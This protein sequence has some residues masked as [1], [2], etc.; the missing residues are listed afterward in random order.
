MRVYDRLLAL[1]ASRIVVLATVL[2][3]VVPAARSELH[4]FDYTWDSPAGSLTVYWTFDDVTNQWCRTGSVQPPGLNGMLYAIYPSTFTNVWSGCTDMTSY[5]VAGTLD[6]AKFR[7]F[8]TYNNGASNDWS[9][10]INIFPGE[11]DTC[12]PVDFQGSV[13]NSGPGDKNY[14][15]IIASDPEETIASFTLEQGQTQQYN[16]QYE[17]L[18]DAIGLWELNE[19]GFPFKLLDTILPDTPNPPDSP[20][21][22]PEEPVDTPVDTP[23]PEYT[24]IEDSI[25]QPLIDDPT[26]SDIEK[27]IESDHILWQRTDQSLKDIEEAIEGDD[28]QGQIDYTSLLE[29]IRDNVKEHNE[30]DDEWTQRHLDAL[31]ANPTESEMA[32]EGQSAANAAAALVPQLS[33][34]G[35]F[36]PGSA[37]EWNISIMEHTFN[38]NPF[39]FPEIVDLANWIRLGFAFFF[40]IGFAT[41]A[42][43]TG[44]EYIQAL[45]QVNQAKGNAAVGGTGGQAT[46]LI[47]AGLITVAVATTLVALFSWA[48][49]D[50][51][52]GDISS[53]MGYHPFNGS[54]VVANAMWMLDQFIPLGGYIGAVIGKIIWRGVA[55]TAFVIAMSI[56]RF[57]VP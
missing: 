54:G 24:P 37:P 57:V 36:S 31:D 23:N 29:E 41:W 17:E 22:P 7:I 45:A 12:G 9:E 21:E 56:I 35:S 52:I 42:S 5:V 20:I 11:P 10:P 6:E 51:G 8:I 26:K 18:C 47:A 34:S 46:A 25:L 32:S 14:A 2:L 33:Y 44:S 3:S 4:S 27:Q 15:I 39:Q 38:M 19:D 13:T 53:M 1:G 30:R 49:Y 40:I 50:I 48:T 28:G 43:T 16:I 55:D